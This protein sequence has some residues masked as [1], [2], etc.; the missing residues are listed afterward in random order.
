MKTLAVS[1]IEDLKIKPFSGSSDTCRYQEIKLMKENA[2]AYLEEHIPD[3]AQTAV[4]IA[5]WQSLAAGYSVLES[6][7]GVIYERFPDGSSKVV[8][9]IEP[10]TTVTKGARRKLV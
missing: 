9:I 4:E 7:N 6:E 3:L 8:K 10:P 2:I 5:Y 1:P